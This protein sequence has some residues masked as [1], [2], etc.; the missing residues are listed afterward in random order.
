MFIVN[1]C[2]GTKAER[3]V[4]LGCVCFACTSICMQVCVCVEQQLRA[5]VGMA[6]VGVLCVFAWVCCQFA[7]CKQ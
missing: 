5:G 4:L 2:S 3:Y 6:A 7:V 1:V